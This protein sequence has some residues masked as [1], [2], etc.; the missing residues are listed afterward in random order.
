MIALLR[1]NVE[2][3][4]SDVGVNCSAFRV[5]NSELHAYNSNIRDPKVNDGEWKAIA[6]P[7]NSN[8]RDPNVN[9]GE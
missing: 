4:N 3:Q 9:D 6:R 5:L 7:L 1:C 8:I 2:V